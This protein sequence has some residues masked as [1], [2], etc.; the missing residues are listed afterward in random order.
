MMVRD[1]FDADD[2]RCYCGICSILVTPSNFGGWDQ[3]DVFCVHC[4][5]AAEAEYGVDEG[6]G[7]PTEAE[8]RRPMTTT[9]ALGLAVEVAM[10]GRNLLNGADEEC[11]ECEPETTEIPVESMDELVNGKRAAA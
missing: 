9:E 10:G 2:T 7:V 11:D 5:T 4:Q 6:V 3:W 1:D 8:Y